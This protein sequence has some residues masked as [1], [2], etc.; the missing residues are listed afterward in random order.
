MGSPA[1]VMRPELIQD[2]RGEQRSLAENVLPPNVSPD[3]LNIDYQDGTVRKRKGI[4]RI[5][6][7]CT[8][9]DLPVEAV[10]QNPDSLW[11]DLFY[12]ATRA[13]VFRVSRLGV[14]TSLFALSTSGIRDFRAQLLAYRGLVVV[15]NGY[16]EN[17]VAQY[18]DLLSLP[19]PVLVSGLTISAAGSGGNIDL[20][21]HKYLFS[22]YNSTTG[23]ESAVATTITT[24]TAAANDKFT[25]DFTSGGW[26]AGTY[27]GADKIRIYRTKAGGAVYYFVAEIAIASTSYIDNTA[28]SGLVT[29]LNS[30]H[31]YAAPSRFGFVFNDSLWLGNQLFGESR[32]VYTEAGTL[33]DFF[34]DNY[35][36]IGLGDGDELTGGIAVGDRC[37]VFKRRSIW[38]VSGVAGSVGVRLLF[39]G[40]GCVQHATIAASDDAVY[41]LAEGGVYRM[42]LP[43]GA[44]TPESL[45]LNG[46]RDF[47]AA[48]D[49]S[50]YEECSAVWDG[51]SERY[52]LSLRVDGARVVLVFCARRNAWALWDVEANGFCVGRVDGA[53]RIYCGWRRWVAL[54]EEG[55]SDGLYL[56][57][58]FDQPMRGVATGGSTTTLENS[59]AAWLSSFGGILQDVDVTVVRADGNET[60]RVTGNT[61]TTLTVDSPWTAPEAGDV[62]YLGAIR[63]TWR[64]PRVGMVR[65][66]VSSRL[67]RVRVLCRAPVSDVEAEGLVTVAVQ[68]DERLPRETFSLRVGD[69]LSSFGVDKGSCTEVRVG[70]E[71]FSPDQTFD[72]AGLALAVA[73]LEELP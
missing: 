50:D 4:S 33:A 20:G 53:S 70:I 54:F 49:N 17:Y 60:R 26:N 36:D 7:S 14:M 47:F 25:L 24:K 66:D 64:T 1:G 11:S 3:G 43:L 15:L 5:G 72:V 62:Y 44:G 46:W 45:T 10:L 69:R 48:M 52:I 37:C 38:G 22:I 42:S 71:D 19:A 61:A 30:Y 13:G 57:D 28:D 58:S 35:V 51:A 56:V 40:V 39:P 73:P 27:A 31:G 2:F 21:V 59:G 18:A 6:Q 65:W 23:A 67:D 8:S 55:R 16:G 12:V 63:A 68:M 34:S 29:I 41:W 9:D 32:L